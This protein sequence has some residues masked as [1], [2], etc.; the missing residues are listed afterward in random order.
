[1]LNTNNLSYWTLQKF[2]YIL[3]PISNMMFLGLDA[4]K[5]AS[6]STLNHTFCYVKSGSVGVSVENFESAARSE[7]ITLSAGSLVEWSGK[8]FIE[9]MGLENDTR[10]LIFDFKILRPSQL[11]RD[12]ILNAISYN[13]PIFM[14]A[15]TI[16][17]PHILELEIASTERRLLES[18]CIE[19]AKRP[20]GYLNKV[21]LL[22]S[23]LVV[24]IVRK[25]PMLPR[26]IDAVAITSYTDNDRPLAANREIFVDDVEIWCGDP[27]EDGAFII[28][29]MRAEN[30]FVSNNGDNITDKINYELVSQNA[31]HK[32]GRLWTGNKPS[33][34]K[35]LFWA[36]KGIKPFDIQQYAQKWIYIK[37]RVKSNA[38]GEV[39]I[40]IY[41]TKGHHWFGSPV[42]I[43]EPDIWQEITVPVMFVQYN[44]ETSPI[45]SKAIRYIH[46]NYSQKITLK[47][48]ADAIYTNPNYLSTVFSREKEM[49]FSAYIR[50]YRLS[51]AQKMLIETDLSAEKIAISV[52]FYDI[53]HFSKLFKKEYGVSP[54]DFRKSNKLLNK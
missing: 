24:E 40:A 28:R 38:S 3:T 47:T 35:V 17:M 25:H 51:V 23:Q 41:S 54:Y 27:E 20:A 39:G 1:M 33:L 21:Q 13:L 9:F 29:T 4:E 2:Q 22:L 34:Y 12:E 32:Y 8:G 18:M 42:M 43:D 15:L 44:R 53:Q 37:T 50:S 36:D 5:T 48:V 49:T 26:Y 30:Y 52:G 46:D 11:D 16:E 10:V 6:I 31:S 19:A 14:Q 45:V 7:R